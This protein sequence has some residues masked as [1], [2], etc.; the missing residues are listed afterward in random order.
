MALAMLISMI[1]DARIEHGVEHVDHEVDQHKNHRHEQHQRLDH[2]VVAA[3]HR[4]HEKLA[5]AVEIEHLFGHHQPAEE[6]RKLDADHGNHRQQRIP[7]RVTRYDQA[8]VDAFGARRADVVFLQHFENAR[9][10]HACR[11]RRIAVADRQRRPDQLQ[12]VG[13]R[14]LHER[15]ESQ[16]R[17]PRKHCQQAKN[18]DHA[19]PE[20]RHRQPGH[21]LALVVLLDQEVQVALV[22]QA[23]VVV[24][25]VVVLVKQLLF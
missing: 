9:T 11:H 8:F 25:E 23:E 13:F 15:R 7:Q 3:R 5:D 1:A 2:G 20:G 19:E 18:D 12:Q 22:V 24:V 14:V 10:H 16:R 6:E 21:T 17:D 4:Q